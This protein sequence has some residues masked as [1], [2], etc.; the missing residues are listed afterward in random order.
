MPLITAPEA[1]IFDLDGVLADTVEYQ[2][3]A[4]RYIAGLIGIPFER[5]DMDRMRGRQRR[6]CLLDLLDG[7]SVTEA[8]IVRL[9]AL[10]D[11]YYLAGIAGMTS[12]N[13]LPGVMPLIQ[14]ARERR[15]KLGVASSSLSALPV[16]EK[17]GLLQMM[18]AVAD[19]STVCRS[20]PAPDIFL[21]T[22]GA[23]GVRPSKVIVFEDSRAGVQAARTAGMTVVGVGD[24]DLTEDAHFRVTSLEEFD[25]DSL[26]FPSSTVDGD[27]NHHT[28][29]GVRNS[30]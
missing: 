1:I 30:S 16:L 8:E 6:D 21:W 28:R 23:L 10:K 18:D 26:F 14:T 19:G 2:Y 22:A 3:Q 17:T 4:W 7:R 25:L 9:M 24:G 15:L 5:G 13:L 20:K 11:E 27:L 29:Q 12:A